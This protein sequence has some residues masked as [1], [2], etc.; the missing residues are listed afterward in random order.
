MRTEEIRKIVLDHR[1][2]GIPLG[3]EI[4]LAELGAQG[5]NVARGELSLPVTTLRADALAHNIATFASY[6]RRRGAELAPHGKTSMSPQLFERQLEAGAWAITAATPGQAQI[7]RK[8]GVP[9]VM[10]AN[11]VVEHAALQWIGAELEA[12][13]GFELLCLV[14]S[15][16][17][18]ELMDA[19]LRDVLSTRRLPVLLELGVSGGR[20]GVRTHEE[21]M[22][23][24]E[25][26][27]ATST[28]ALAGV[29]T[30]E[31]LAASEASEQE[32]KAVD[33]LLDRVRVVVR[34]IAAANLFAPGEVLVTAGGSIHF[35]R[36]VDHLSGWPDSA[37]SPKLVLRSGCYVSHDS[38]RYHRLSP[39]DGRRSGDEP[40]E[41]RNALES[42]A[43][44]LSR[45]EPGLVIAGAGKRDLPYDVEMPIPLRAH[46]RGGEVV[47]LEDC[48]V[49][50]MMDQHAFLAVPP[51]TDLA[52]GD[53]IVFG[54]SHPCAAFDKA[55]LLPLIDDDYTVVDGVVTFF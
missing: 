36:V 14:D 10:I 50:K 18:V 19:A 37:V 11:E 1:Y 33:A 27:G 9:R 28:L 41:L 53:I 24:A 25:A 31:G 26:I 15:V 6:C 23:V 47:S 55:P 29:E 35:D 38:G 7:M 30:Y 43:T 34:D 52:A 54:L 45:P 8:F 21:A 40:L 5:W 2:K 32:L 3:V 17:T 42:W 16:A 48:T 20:T 46:R 39:L 49:T 4:P 13:P 22:A 51:E 44:V 12:D